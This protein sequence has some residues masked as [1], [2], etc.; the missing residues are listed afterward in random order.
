MQILLVLKKQNSFYLM[1]LFQV[2][3]WVFVAVTRGIKCGI[4]YCPGKVFLM[5]YPGLSCRSL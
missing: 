4:K 2:M 5:A 3:L 1:S